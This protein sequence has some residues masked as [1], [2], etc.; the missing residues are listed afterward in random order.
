MYEAL[1]PL[2]HHLVTD[3]QLVLSQ[4]VDHAYHSVSQYPRNYYGWTYLIKLIASMPDSFV[5]SIRRGLKD[6][7]LKKF[8]IISALLALI[9]QIILLITIEKYVYVIQM[10]LHRTC[11]RQD[12]SLRHSIRNKKRVFTNSFM[13]TIFLFEPLFSRISFF[14]SFLSPDIKEMKASGSFWRISFFSYPFSLN[15]YLFH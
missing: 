14:S 11:M 7:Y 2:H 4:E 5:F 1:I 12:W 6:R 9:S 15:S 13:R 8:S 3:F 10:D